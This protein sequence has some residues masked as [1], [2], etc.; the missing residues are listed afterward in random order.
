MKLPYGIK[1]LG[2]DADIIVRC[3]RKGLKGVGV[4]S[5][6]RVLALVPMMGAKDKLLWNDFR[7]ESVR[8]GRRLLVSEKMLLAWFAGATKAVGDRRWAKE[9]IERRSAS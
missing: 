1:R 2:D 5:K 4:G 7:L 6:W 8:D 3:R 9:F